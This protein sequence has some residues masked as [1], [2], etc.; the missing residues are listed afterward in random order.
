[1]S[2]VTSFFFS[3]IKLFLPVAKKRIKQGMCHKCSLNVIILE[4]KMLWQLCRE[5]PAV[6]GEEISP[7]FSWRLVIIE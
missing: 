6:F 7:N 1:M 4:A 2:T 5:Y 3:I